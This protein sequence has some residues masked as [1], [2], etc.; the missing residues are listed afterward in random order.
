MED[1]YGCVGGPGVCL[2]TAG[3]QRAGLSALQAYLV[4][5]HTQGCSSCAL[6]MAQA[7]R[8][9]VAAGTAPRSLVR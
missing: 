8:R 1:G 3:A 2:W 9:V 5:L 6:P 4:C 7:K